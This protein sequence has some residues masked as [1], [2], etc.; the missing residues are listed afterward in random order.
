MSNRKRMEG[1][2]KKK[3]KIK[4]ARRRRNGARGHKELRRVRDGEEKDRRDGK[5]KGKLKAKEIVR[6]KRRGYIF[7]E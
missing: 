6:G 4:R 2:K 5:E 1:K 7:K 3:S